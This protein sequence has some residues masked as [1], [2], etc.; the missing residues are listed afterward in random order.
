MRKVF[1]KLGQHIPEMPIASGDN[2]FTSREYADYLGF[3]LRPAQDR[4]KRL[5]REGRIRQVRTKRAGKLVPAWEY[6][7]K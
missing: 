5:Q 1:Q 7:S 2:V 4:I 3:N 6:V